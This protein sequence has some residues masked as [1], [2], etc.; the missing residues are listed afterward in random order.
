MHDGIQ[1]DRAHSRWHV[2]Q[3]VCILGARNGYPK[4]LKPLRKWQSALGFRR[5][6]IDTLSHYSRNIV[7]WKNLAHFTFLCWQRISKARMYGGRLM[8]RRSC[9]WTRRRSAAHSKSTRR[10]QLSSNAPIDSTLL[11]LQIRSLCH[12]AYMRPLPLS[13]PHFIFA[14]REYLVG[15]QLCYLA[16][17]IF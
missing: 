14:V 10:C 15:L 9:C 4:A 1:S 5:V 11:P 16:H 12:C 2:I 7:V 17:W 3:P 6:S 13:A 8:G